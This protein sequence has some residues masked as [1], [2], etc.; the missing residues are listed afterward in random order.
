MF[1]KVY[2][3]LKTNLITQSSLAVSDC[4][5]TQRFVTDLPL[6]ALTKQKTKTKNNRIYS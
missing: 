6:C 4:F 1:V 2:D 5:N 3:V